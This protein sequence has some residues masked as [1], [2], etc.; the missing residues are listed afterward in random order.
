M[1]ICPKC[2]SE[3]PETT[4]FCMKDGTLLPS[5]DSPSM[6]P[7]PNVTPTKI[8]KRRG[9]FKLLGNF[10]TPADNEIEVKSYHCT[11]FK[12][13]LL[14]LK[15][16]GYLVVTNKRVIFHA[17]GMSISG[18]SILQSEVPIEDVSGLNLY[19]GSYLS[20]MHILGA[21]IFA[22]V[23]MAIMNGLAL[24][25]VQVMY[26]NATDLQSIEVGTQILYWILALG[27][28]GGSFVFKRTSIFRPAFVAISAS[29]FTLLGGASLLT[30]FA[31]SFLSSGQATGDYFI[32]FLGF[33]VGIY[34]LFCVFWY[35]RRPTMSL[36]VGS[37]G[38]SSTPIAI[39]GISGFGI[40][41]TSAS[42]A[43][44]AEPAE[45][46]ESLLKE[47]GA[48]IMD[49]QVLGDL[50]INQWQSGRGNQT[51]KPDANWSQ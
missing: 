48:L 18:K 33:L 29:F 25:M 51:G 26:Q 10:L 6:P 4:Q 15:A 3:Y 50:G 14:N 22:S 40:L 35:A 23:I 13:F 9:I 19:K 30:S 42:K 8:H 43:L 36:S 1:K 34:A 49:I 41:N 20:F 7:P 31:S 17:S 21:F 5:P 27:F 12:S 37:K 45:D 16:E 32:L 46:A 11:S 2:G 28:L 39:S 38:G 44:S 24:G 47:L